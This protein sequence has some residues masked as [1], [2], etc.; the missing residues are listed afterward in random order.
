MPDGM[1]VYG[2]FTRD[3]R[4]D[5][6]ECQILVTIPECLE[7]FTYYNSVQLCTCTV[8]RFNKFLSLSNYRPLPLDIVAESHGCKM[9]KESEVCHL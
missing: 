3:F 8:N 2:V 5:A 7:V 1:H 9:A 6:M 4:Q